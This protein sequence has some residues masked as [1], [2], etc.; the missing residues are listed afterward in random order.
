MLYDF[1][2]AVSPT[3]SIIGPAAPASLTH[4][5]SII[6]ISSVSS[7]PQLSPDAFRRAGAELWAWVLRGGG[8]GGGVWGEVKGLWR[9]LGLNSQPAHTL[10]DS[11]SVRVLWAQWLQGRGRG[12]AIQVLLT[13]LRQA[14]RHVLYDILRRNQG[15]GLKSTP[16]LKLNQDLYQ[17]MKMGFWRLKLSIIVDV[18]NWCFIF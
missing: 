14:S 3:R 12:R 6:I 5:S 1:L 10:Q 18:V 13:G 7:S 11:D 8:G 15:S 9:T 16:I 17:K 4:T 2:F